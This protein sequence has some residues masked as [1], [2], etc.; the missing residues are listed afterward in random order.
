MSELANEIFEEEVSEE[1]QIEEVAVLDD[2]SAEYLLRRIR[3]AN[4]QYER[5]ESWYIHQ[6]EKA[7]EIRDRTVAWA[8]RGL[9]SYLEMIPAAKRTKTQLSYEL[10]GGKLVLKNQGPEYERDEAALV[11][12]LKENGLTD[13]VKVK[14]SANWAELKKTL[15]ETPDGASMMTEDGEIVP[16]VKVTQREPK[17]EAIPNTKRN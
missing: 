14:E 4:E 10:P 5:M 1:E 9:R 11:P 12:W 16:G 13:L 6:T 8:E 15:R 17:F 3:E 2:A 7:K